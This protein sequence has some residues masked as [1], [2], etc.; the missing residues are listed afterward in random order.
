MPASWLLDHELL[1]ARSL[2]FAMRD[3]TGKLAVGVMGEAK[4]VFMDV[5]GWTIAKSRDKGAVSSV[6]IK[7]VFG[8][9]VVI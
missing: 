3:L 5:C 2:L 4:S 1:F 8:Q 9:N 7:A 6:V